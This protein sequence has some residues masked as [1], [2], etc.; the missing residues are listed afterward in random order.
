MA[1]SIYKIKSGDTLSGIATANKSTVADLMKYNPNIKDPNKISAGANL[2]LSMPSS[3]T[4][5]APVA[6]APGSSPATT[7]I[8]P[9]STTSSSSVKVDATKPPPQTLE[10]YKAS[11]LPETPKPAAPN[12]VDQYQ[13]L[14][15]SQGITSLEDQVTADESQKAD[16]L[17]ALDK[18]KR[19]DVGSGEVTT[20]MAAGRLSVAA[21]NIQDKIDAINR[22]EAISQANLTTKN[23][24]ISSV[25]SFTEK[26]YGAV[27]DAYN[28]AF[29]QALSAQN[30]F[31]TEQSKK[32]TQDNLVVD[33]ARAN[34]TAMNNVLANSSPEQIQTYFNDPNNVNAIQ[35]LELQAGIQPGTFQAFANAKPKANVVGT[36]TGYDAN[37][38]GITSIINQDSQ[39]NLTTTIIPNGTVA[40][41]TIEGAGTESTASTKGIPNTELTN[42]AQAANDWE[43]YSNAVARFGKTAVDGYLKSINDKWVPP[44]DPNA[45]K[46]EDIWSLFFGG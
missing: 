1:D 34:L 2:N 4:P 14:R 22:R 32:A 39:G 8:T 17:D 25:M 31:N 18:Q 42:V 12:Y 3:A 40:P 33:N 16:L 20:G 6:P 46:R 26:D 35:Q 28:T 9:P 38:K 11:I 19:Q 15:Q 29:N 23:N 27:N 21:Q 41:K 5:P 13:K 24:Y 37:G 44:T 7:P 30:S 36:S 43:S 10:Q 45:P